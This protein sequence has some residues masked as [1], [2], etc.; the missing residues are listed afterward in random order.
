[1][2]DAPEPPSTP[3]RE[4]AGLTARAEKRL[5]VWIAERVPA[6]L[7]PDHFTA[8]GLLGMVGAG[9]GYAL[10]ARDPRWLHAVNL[11]LVLNWL[12]D[13]LDGTL[14][15]VRNRLRPRYGFYVDH[16]V[17]AIGALFLLLGLAASG[18][19]DPRIA[20][21]L[22]IAYYFLNLNIYLAASALGVYKI[23][24]GA[25]GGTELRILLVIVNLLALCCPRL[26]LAGRSLRLFDLLLGAGVAAVAFV[27]L[28]S[29]AQVTGRLYRDERL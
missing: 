6:A 7:N 15:R 2:T 1:M 11:C 22:L 12:G 27:A 20:L 5:L 26:E 9:A 8:L 4:L 19:C 14:A 23:S 3:Q 29:A 17:D 10:A 16:L 25:I 24:Y 21:A 13:S 28:R 18:L